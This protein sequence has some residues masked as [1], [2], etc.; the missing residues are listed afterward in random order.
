MIKWIYR[1]PFPEF[2]LH[3]S[4]QPH[5]ILTHEVLLSAVQSPRKKILWGT[6][7]SL[8][9]SRHCCRHF[10]ILTGLAVLSFKV[11]VPLENYL[12]QYSM[13]EFVKNLQPRAFCVFGNLTGVG[14]VV[15]FAFFLIAE[16]TEHFFISFFPFV[17]LPRFLPFHFFLLICKCHTF[18]C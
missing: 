11:V 4:P 6:H 16:H 12:Q 9:H 15:F 14:F 1:G 8:Y 5:N 17:S 10:S 13:W 18:W 3:L 2:P 7:L